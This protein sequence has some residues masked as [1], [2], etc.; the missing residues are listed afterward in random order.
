MIRSMII[1][2][3]TLSSNFSAFGFKFKVGFHVTV[4]Y[5][6]LALAEWDDC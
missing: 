4:H 2:T 5:L 6:P 1:L 3:V